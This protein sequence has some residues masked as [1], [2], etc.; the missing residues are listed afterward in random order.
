ME[1]VYQF[2][3]LNMGWCVS[4]HVNGYKPADAVRNTGACPT[5]ADLA[6]S[7]KE[8]TVRLRRL[9]LLTRAPTA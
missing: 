6:L 5:P 9:P 4:C 7:A 1:R 2:A 8:S 3:S